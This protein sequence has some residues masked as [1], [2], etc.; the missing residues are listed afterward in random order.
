GIE[1][2]GLT[3]PP[4][5]MVCESCLQDAVPGEG[6]IHGG[7]KA[8]KAVA[9]RAMASSQA[10]DMDWRNSMAEEYQNER[11]P[12]APQHQSRPRV[13]GTI[14]QTGTPTAPARWAVV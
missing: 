6:A 2:I 8:F 5:L 7:G 3:R 13:D 10:P 11:S 9:M 12:S 1:R 14:T 4:G